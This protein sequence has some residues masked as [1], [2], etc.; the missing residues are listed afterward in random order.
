MSLRK[1][2]GGASTEPCHGVAT[3]EGESG[4]Q[5]WSQVGG[6]GD[7]LGTKPLKPLPE[8]EEV[9]HDSPFRKMLRRLLPCLRPNKD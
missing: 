6:I 4:S 2:V 8:K 7:T 1:R 9:F 5:S 3:L